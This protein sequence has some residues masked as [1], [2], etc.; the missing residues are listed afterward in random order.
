MS[1]SE[2]A[3]LKSELQ[4]I[5][6]RLDRIESSLEHRKVMTHKEF[7][8]IQ[9]EINSIASLRTIIKRVAWMAAGILASVITIVLQ[10]FLGA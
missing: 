1:E 6:K 4:H 8:D 7:N 2:I 9:V 5:V 10:N 3:V